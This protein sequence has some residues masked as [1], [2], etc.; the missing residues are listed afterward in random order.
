MTTV[1]TY[2]TEGRDDVPVGKLAACKVA[3]LLNLPGSVAVP[4]NIWTHI[5]CEEKQHIT[6]ESQI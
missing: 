5:S 2:F 6:E 3:C 1:T 4:G